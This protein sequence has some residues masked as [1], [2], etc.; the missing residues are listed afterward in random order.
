VRKMFIFEWWGG[1]CPAWK[2]SPDGLYYMPLF[3]GVWINIPEPIVPSNKSI[4][5]EVYMDG[6][7]IETEYVSKDL[8]EASIFVHL[9]D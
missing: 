2:K 7:L 5:I 8:N 4:K 3:L 1:L 9:D 6:D